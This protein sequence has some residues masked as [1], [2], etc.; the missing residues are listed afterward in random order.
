M[1]RRVMAVTGLTHHPERRR[2]RWFS[3]LMT[4]RLFRTRT[5]ATGSTV[6]GT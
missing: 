4:K 3:M 6:A 1:R 2:H 5:L